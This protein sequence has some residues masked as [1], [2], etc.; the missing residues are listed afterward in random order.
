MVLQ[1][2]FI[3]KLNEIY[4]REFTGWDFSSMEGVGK[5]EEF[6]LD[7]DYKDIL[8]PYLLDR[9]SMLDMGT[10]GGEFLSTLTPLSEITTAT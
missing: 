3:K 5:M 4:N 10:E 7:W 9:S 8:A 2:E 6:P 1:E